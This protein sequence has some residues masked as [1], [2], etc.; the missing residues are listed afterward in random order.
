MKE[1]LSSFSYSSSSRRASCVM[2]VSEY[3][4]MTSSSSIRASFS[5]GTLMFFSSVGVE[6]GQG[7]GMKD[8]GGMSPIKSKEL[9]TAANNF[10]FN[11]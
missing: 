4:R 8:A 2:S 3:W 11:R 7:E 9:V 10:R 6:M 5:S 1:F